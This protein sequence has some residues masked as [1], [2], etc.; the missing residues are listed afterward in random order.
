MAELGQLEARHADLDAKNTRL[1]AVSLDN[2]DDTAAMQKK[3]PHLTL[4]SDADR[5]LVDAA[6]V[7]GP[8]RNPLDGSQ[9]VAPTTVLIDRSGTVRWLFRPDRY[10]ERLSPDDL[11]ANV[12]EHLKT[13]TPRK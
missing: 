1:V 8:Q 5:S 11:L 3:F 4:V 10:L 12:V 7:L 2:V 13:S 6:G 9:T